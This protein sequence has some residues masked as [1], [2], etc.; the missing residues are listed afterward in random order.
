MDRIQRQ[1][2]TVMTRYLSL[3]AVAAATDRVQCPHRAAVTTCPSHHEITAL[4]DRI[5][6]D[7][8]TAVTRCR[9]HRRVTPMPPS[10]VHRRLASHS[11]QRPGAAQPN[12]SATSPEV[13]PE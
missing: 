7:H 5:Q 1:R 3:H 10:Q 9:P 12:I 13:V 8:S 4:M 2:R 6:R 11:T